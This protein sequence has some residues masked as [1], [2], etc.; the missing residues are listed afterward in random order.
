MRPLEGLIERRKARGIT[1]T[2]M[3][4]T[5]GVGCGHYRKMEKGETTLDIRRA[6]V[7]ARRLGC[8]MEDL[9]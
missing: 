1:A 9:V 4:R 7:L 8:T 6:R 2:D 3:G 5:I